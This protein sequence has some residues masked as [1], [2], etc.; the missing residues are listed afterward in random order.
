M[1]FLSCFFAK[2]ITQIYQ[3]REAVKDVLLRALVS[4][5]QQE[6]GFFSYTNLKK[7]CDKYLCRGGVSPPFATIH[8][9]RALIESV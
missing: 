7:E 1:Y 3:R 6:R 5:K 8:M 4:K 9:S 2:L